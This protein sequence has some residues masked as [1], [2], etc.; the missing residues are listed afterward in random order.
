[1]DLSA[2]QKKLAELKMKFK[3]DSN[4]ADSG[5]QGKVFPKTTTNSANQQKK[6]L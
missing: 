4:G 1:M 5:N 2:S 6:V 3:T